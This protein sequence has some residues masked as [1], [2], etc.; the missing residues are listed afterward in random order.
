M[1]Q[2]ETVDRNTEKSPAV[3]PRVGELWPPI[4]LEVRIVNPPPSR[5][6]DGD[7]KNSPQTGARAI[8]CAVLIGFAL[9]KDELLF[10]AILGLVFV[11]LDT[12]VLDRLS[13]LFRRR[14]PEDRSHEDSSRQERR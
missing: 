9:G 10:G 4:E 1:Y 6:A 8:L 13:T 14:P 3:V 7:D 2:D 5:S 12:R 11:G